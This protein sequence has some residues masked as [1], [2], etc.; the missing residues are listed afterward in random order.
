MKA[1]ELNLDDQTT[2]RRSSEE[3]IAE[4]LSKCGRDSL[5]YP[6]KAGD[7]STP[8]QPRPA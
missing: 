1:N 2:D 5:P 4:S 6:G 8:S 3:L 7:G